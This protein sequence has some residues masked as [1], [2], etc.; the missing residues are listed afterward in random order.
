MLKV[1]A[2]AGSLRKESYNHKLVSAAAE[3]ARAS[4]D[5]EVMLVRL[6]DYEMPFMNEDLEGEK[7][8]PEN[9]RRFRELIE[10]S[11]ALLISS[12]E[13]NSSITGVLKNA[14]DWASRPPKNVWMGKPVMVL[15]ASPGAFGASSSGFQTR[16]ILLQ[17]GAYVAPQ[18]VACPHADEAFNEQGQLVNEFVQK[19]LKKMVPGFLEFAKKLN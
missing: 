14:I 9:A 7:G 10:K 18:K 3:T 12:P 6:N 5:V 1:L 15:S 17:L 19:N 2:F 13:Y 4:G 8:L 16:Q 11:D